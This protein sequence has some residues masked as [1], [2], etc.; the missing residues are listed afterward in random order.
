LEENGRLLGCE[1]PESQKKIKMDS[2]LSFRRAQQKSRKIKNLEWVK[3]KHA[4]QHKVST[5]FIKLGTPLN[6]DE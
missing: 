6:L 3:K 4:S 2:P 1:I 5:A